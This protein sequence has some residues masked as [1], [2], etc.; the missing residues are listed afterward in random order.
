MAG[1]ATGIVG[2]DGGDGNWWSCTTQETS[3]DGSTAQE[4]RPGDALNH[5]HGPGGRHRTWQT[6]LTSI[7]LAQSSRGV[8]EWRSVVIEALITAAPM[9][10]ASHGVASLVESS[11][12]THSI[13]QVVDSAAGGEKRDCDPSAQSPWRTGSSTSPRQPRVAIDRRSAPPNLNYWW[14]PNGSRPCA[15][16]ARGRGKAQNSHTS[17]LH[18]GH[19]F[20]S[21]SAWVTSVIGNS[22]PPSGISVAGTSGLIDGRHTMGLTSTQTMTSLSRSSTSA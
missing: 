13:T 2:T 11:A 10:A 21:T 8:P 4:Q 5:G 17:V 14:V 22:S 16:G 12:R 18:T 20:L 6:S 9:T 1:M 7:P 19:G 15:C 3:F